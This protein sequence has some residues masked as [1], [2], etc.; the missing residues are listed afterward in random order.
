MLLA[1][2]LLKKKVGEREGGRVGGGEGLM[3]KKKRTSSWKFYG[4]LDAKMCNV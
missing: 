3:E 4:C 2:S 1:P